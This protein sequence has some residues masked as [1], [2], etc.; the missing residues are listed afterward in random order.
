MGRNGKD[1]IIKDFQSVNK[2]HS[3]EKMTFCL[4]IENI[5]LVNKEKGQKI[6]NKSFSHKSINFQ[7]LNKLKITSSSTKVKK[8]LGHYYYF[9]TTKFTMNDIKKNQNDKELS[10]DNSNLNYQYENSST[11][12]LKE[13]SFRSLPIWPTKNYHSFTYSLK[14][15]P[16]DSNPNKSFLTQVCKRIDSQENDLFPESTKISENNHLTSSNMQTNQSVTSY[17]NNL[18]SYS[19][20]ENLLKMINLKQKGNLYDK[21]IFENI[22][23]LTDNTHYCRKLQEIVSEKVE[24]EDINLDLYIEHL[25]PSLVKLSYSKFG[26]YLVQNLIEKCN[27]CQ[28]EL[29]FLILKKSFSLLAFSP[30]GTRVIQKIIENNNSNKIV[31]MIKTSLK[32]RLLEYM[33]TQF[34]I[35]VVFVYMNSFPGK[36]SWFIFNELIKHSTEISCSKNGCCLIQKIIDS[37]ENNKYLAKLVESLST[38]CYNLLKDNAGHYI[39]QCLLRNYSKFPEEVK[40]IK[41]VILENLRVLSRFK[42]FGS[43]I[44]MIIPIEK[45]EFICEMALKITDNS[46][47]EDLLSFPSGAFIIQKLLRRIS[48][49]YY[50]MLIKKFKNISVDLYTK[51]DRIIKNIFQEHNL[52]KS[53]GPN[54]D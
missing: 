4:T 21:Y 38:N 39:V 54:Q 12:D 30:Y 49:P 17:N 10:N 11:I 24:K 40:N 50:K 37:F 15:I 7:N 28:L 52:E 19:S 45:D 26:N 16:L 14:Y 9:Y 53:Y 18:F 6:R 46:V 25:M 2:S 5:C 43:F 13:M 34:S 51:T 36:N 41:R 27:A 3:H 29:V 20:I 32:A 22:H 1:L 31:K 47:F 35:Y 48:N 8:F 23:F 44:E 33:T 42:H